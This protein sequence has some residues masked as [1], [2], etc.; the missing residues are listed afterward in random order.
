MKQELYCHL[1]H[2]KKVKVKSFSCVQL[3]APHGQ[4]YKAPPSMEFSSGLPFPSPG[5]SFRLRD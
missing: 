1:N 2:I 3:F 5:E 4:S